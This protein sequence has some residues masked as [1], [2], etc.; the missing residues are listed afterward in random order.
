MDYDD[1]FIPADDDHVKREKNKA[2]EMR[3]AAWW[4]NQL[5]KGQCYYCH[6]R[7]HP[8]VLTMDH[9][10]PIIRG[11]KT[12]KGNVVT[13]CKDCNSKKKYMLPI[14]WQAYVNGQ[15]NEDPPKD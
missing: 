4:K 5:G 14:E 7:F 15:L 11:G 1:Y 6:Q 9:V 12:T 13:C 3:K 8:S 2:R 10:V